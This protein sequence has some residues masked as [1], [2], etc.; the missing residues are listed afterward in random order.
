M[1]I[2]SFY[3]HDEDEQIRAAMR[4]SLQDTPKHLSPVGQ[5]ASSRQSADFVDLTAD[6]EPDA[7]APK[8]V[9]SN[10]VI[11]DSDAELERAIQLSLINEGP[12]R[13]QHGEEVSVP[14]TATQ[15]NGKEPKQNATSESSGNSSLG[16]M[17]F[18]RKKMEEERLARLERKRK[19]PS[20]SKSPAAKHV[21]L[22]SEK[23]DVPVRAAAFGSPTTKKEVPKGK[24]VTVNNEVPPQPSASPSLQF[25]SG[26]VKKTWAY[27]YP[28]KGDDIKLEEVVQKTDLELAVLSSY[29]WDTD[30]LFSKFIIGK[31]R[32]LLIM[33]EKEE[34]RRRALIEDTESVGSIRLCFPPMEP[35]VNCMHS[36][37]MLLFHPTY[38]RVVVPSANL[39]PFD[40]GEDGGTMENIVFL[41]DLP[42]KSLESQNVPRTS[43]LDDLVYFLQAS[44]LNEKIIE[45]M[46]KFD[47]STTKDMAF[48]HTI[49]GSHKNEN[50]KRTG[51]CGLGRALTSL[52]LQTSQDQNLDYITSSVGDDG[53]KEFT[54]RTSKTFPSDKWGVITE[55]TDGAKWKD[56]FR[57]Y[58]PSL[59]TVRQ[60]KAGTRG[61]GT[62]CFQSKWY[63]SATFPQE[64]MRSNVSR[65][66]RMLMHNKM[67]F[68]RPDKPFISSKN[69]S[70]RFAGWAYVG[71]ANL[72]ESA[73]GRLVLDRS[74]NKPKLNCRNWECGVV[75]PIRQSEVENTK[76]GLSS[77][78]STGSTA[79]LTT[80]PE[81]SI[82]TDGSDDTDGGSKIAGVF[83]STIPIP[84][85]VPASGYRP[86]DRPWF[87]S[88]E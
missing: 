48:V 75:L 18:D 54:L 79:T 59:N 87:Y 38:L 5:P 29:M 61:A 57:V 8:A 47:F 34:E 51:L 77:I 55:R 53:L 3:N 70:T 63:N 30:W 37:L 10:E 16:I 86:G 80:E 42:R 76:T 13:R 56:R 11:D 33:G 81:L 39:V 72:S 7:E 6:S 69:D 12:L 14:E 74:T 19:A 43:F 26:V 49:G 83:G 41:I 17:G 60:S 9:L 24:E 78:P 85:H 40:W 50:W 66:D 21:A 71:S 52:G 20:S 36:K 1:D 45:K 73:W 64:I 65:R 28:R 58:F 27:G 88:E 4:A 67:L 68:V 82:H 2:N 22:A 62:I 32:F 46:Q 84:M 31:T 44:N 23:K 25:P 15:R 35:Q